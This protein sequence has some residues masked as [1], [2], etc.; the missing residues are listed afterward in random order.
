[1]VWK[2][3]HLVRKGVSRDTGK[4]ITWHWIG[5]RDTG[6]D[7]VILGRTGRIERWHRPE[8]HA[9]IQARKPRSWYKA[10]GNLRSAA[11]DFARHRQDLDHG[12]SKLRVIVAVQVDSLRLSSSLGVTV[13]GVLLRKS[14]S[15]H[16]HVCATFPYLWTRRRNLMEAPGTW[17]PS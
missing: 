14:F 3:G 8:L 1:M 4:R 9:E 16:T 17:F 6:P 12:W 13:T 2:A 5:S 7:H 10:G 15:W 11:S